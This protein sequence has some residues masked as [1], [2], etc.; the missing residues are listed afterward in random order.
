M[1]SGEEKSFLVYSFKPQ[2]IMFASLQFSHVCSKGCEEVTCD[3][4]KR[5]RCIV[6]SSFINGEDS[7]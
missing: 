2:Q 3:C 4:T 7:K 5:F 6:A 1:L